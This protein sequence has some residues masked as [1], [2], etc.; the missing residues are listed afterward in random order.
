MIRGGFVTIAGAPTPG[1]SYSIDLC[2][3][4]NGGVFPLSTV[5]ER[6]LPSEP[7]QEFRPASEPVTRYLCPGPAYVL[8]EIWQFRAPVQEPVLSNDVNHPHALIDT[9]NKSPS[10]HREAW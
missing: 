4:Q 1:T 3:M 10:S 7:S 2:E 6:Q 9:S 5:P 8:P